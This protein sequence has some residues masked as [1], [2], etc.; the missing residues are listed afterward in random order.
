MD[1][2]NVGENRCSRRKIGLAPEFLRLASPRRRRE[3]SGHFSGHLPT[4]NENEIVDVI[5]N[6]SDDEP[7]SI[8]S[9]KT[10]KSKASILSITTSQR[11]IVRR[12]KLQ[13]EISSMERI[14]KMQDELERK[15]LEVEQSRFQRQADIEKRRLEMEELALEDS[16]FEREDGHNSVVIL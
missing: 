6:T 4:T 14:S 1:G 3:D 2:E 15:R 9:G 7:E 13:A 16:D 8:V 11:S 12:Q 10:R 5:R